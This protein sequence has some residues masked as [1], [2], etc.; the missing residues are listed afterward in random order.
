MSHEDN[1]AGFIFL[2]VRIIHG[3]ATA[4]VE[5]P[6][7]TADELLQSVVPPEGRYRNPDDS[8]MIHHAD[9]GRL[10]AAFTSGGWTVHH[11][12]NDANPHHPADLLSAVRH[13]IA[14]Y[15]IAGRAHGPLP[16]VGSRA[17]TAAP[18]PVRLAAVLLLAQAWVYT[19][20]P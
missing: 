3:T 11:Y 7:P 13:F 9:L 16:D 5:L 17:W 12:N 10:V 18:E 1:P 14:P 8:W 6:D 19:R 20:T 2:P 4:R 15:L